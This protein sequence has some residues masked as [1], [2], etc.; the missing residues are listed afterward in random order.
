VVWLNADVLPGPGSALVAVA[1]QPFLASCAELYP[2]GVLSLGWRTHLAYGARYTNADCEAMR[3][4]LAAHALADKPVSQNKFFLVY[5]SLFVCMCVFFLF[6]C[7]FF[8]I[9][10]NFPR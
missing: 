3:A 6:L 4:L 1:A 2:E 5:L 8:K 10:S 7:I 9:L